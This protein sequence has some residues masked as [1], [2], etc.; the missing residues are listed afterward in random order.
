[1]PDFTV[2][3][4]DAEV[5]TLLALSEVRGVDANTVLKQALGTEKLIAE[6]VGKQDELLIRRGNS[7][8]FAK[9]EFAPAR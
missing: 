5:S 2:S 9:V 4:T 8:T 1:M 7:D 3:L 6:N